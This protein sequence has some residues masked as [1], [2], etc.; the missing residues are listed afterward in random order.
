MNDNSAANEIVQEKPLE[1]H[2]VE[3]AEYLEEDVFD[4]L[5][6]EHPDEELIVKKLTSGGGKLLVGPRG[7]GKTTLMLKA[8]NVALGAE[9][10]STLPIYVN[11]KFSLKLEPLYTAN[12]NA[13]YWFRAWLNL[14]VAQALFASLNKIEEI[15]EHRL[16]IQGLSR[17]ERMISRIESGDVEASGHHSSRVDAPDTGFSS[18]DLISLILEALEKSGRARCVI[19]MDDAAH[20]FSQRQQEDFFDFFRQVKRR[21]IAPKAAIYPGITIHSHSF[22]VGHDAE[23]IDVWIKPEGDAYE[24]FMM[25]LAEKRFSGVLPRCLVRDPDVIPFLAYASFG[26]P[27]S[28]LNMLREVYDNESGYTLTDGSINKSKALGLSKYARDYAVNVYEALEF[29]MP[30]YKN[31]VHSG[32]EIFEKISGNLKDFNRVKHITEQALSVGIRRPQPSELEKVLGFLQYAGLMMP[33]GDSSRG[34]KGI[35]DLFVP[36]FGALISDNSVVGKRT[37]TISQFVTVFRH[38]SHQTW[39]RISPDR[40][41]DFGTDDKAFSLSLAACQRCGTERLSEH[42]KFC[43]NCGTQLKSESLYRELVGQDIDVLK[44]GPKLASRIKKEAGLLKISDILLDFDRSKLRSVRMI[45]P[46]R[47]ARIFSAAEEYMA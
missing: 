10:A 18:E 8:Y 46:I 17:V 24:R 27:R 4:E 26:I 9:A 44:M 37:K 6:A 40:L 1:R 16:D 29:K 15:T 7:C 19:L 34:D 39:P 5:N 30:I 11:F 31:F 33:R 41:M 45:G 22:Q 42:S 47:A 25:E 2:F 20:A 35:F 14:K 43:H 28:F 38:R 3:Q 13:S 12:A 32:S 36:H 21:E 23:Q